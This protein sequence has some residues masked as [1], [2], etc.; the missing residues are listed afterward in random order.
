MRRWET[1]PP[2][3]VQW[4]RGAFDA[5]Y[6][7]AKHGHLTA[8]NVSGGAGA[9]A[10]DGR[11]IAN[12]WASCGQFALAPT[13]DAFLRGMLFALLL[14]PAFALCAMMLFLRNLF[15]CYAALHTIFAIIVLV[16]GILGAIGLA[17][18]P[19]ESLCFAVVIGVSVDYLV[20]FAYAYKHSLMAEEYYKTRAVL[21]ARSGSA[22]A[23]GVTTL[24][25]VLPLTA[26]GLLPLRVFGIIFTVVAL[27]SLG[28]AMGLFNALLMTFGNGTGMSVHSMPSRSA[29]PPLRSGRALEPLVEAARAAAGAPAAQEEAGRGEEEQD[30]EFEFEFGDEALTPRGPLSAGWDQ[31]GDEGQTNRS[32]ASSESAASA[33]PMARPVR[34]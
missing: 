23:S 34:V 12:G 5:H 11:T 20:H 21:M 16:L 2:K 27:V 1:L 26:A 15:L 30:F 24:C 32:A 18:G 7:P 8:A 31:R 28:C 10:V 22:M 13:L 19:I 33:V 14:T 17:L 3:V 29:L 4:Q 9:P 25:A 6:D